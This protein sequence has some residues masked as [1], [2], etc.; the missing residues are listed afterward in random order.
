MHK[1]FKTAAFVLTLTAIGAIAATGPR[2]KLMSPVHATK[3]QTVQ[4]ATPIALGTGTYYHIPT[5]FASIVD[6][7]GDVASRPKYPFGLYELPSE[8]GQTL[9]AKSDNLLARYGGVAIDGYYYNI[10]QWGPIYNPTY[11]LRKFDMTTWELVEEKTLSD[12]SL[13]ADCMAYDP[14][15][16]KTYGCFRIENGNRISFKIGRT[17]LTS[18][19]PYRT[20]LLNCS[21]NS[22]RWNACACTPDGKLY[23][24]N[25]DGDLLRIDKST[26]KGSKIGS[27]GITPCNLAAATI[28]PET[29]IMYY[30]PS[31][32]DGSVSIY[33]VDLSSGKATEALRLPSHIVLTGLVPANRIPASGVPAIPSDARPEFKDGN[34]SGTINF[35]APSTTFDGKSASGQLRYEITD[36]DGGAVISSGT[37][38]Y[39]SNVS[40]PATLAASGYHNLVITTENSKGRSP[41]L[42]TRIYAGADKPRRTQTVTAVLNDATGEVSLS[43]DAVTE[44]VYGG[45]FNA[46]AVTYSVSDNTTGNVIA[47][48]LT[49][50]SYTARLNDSEELKCHR[51]DVRASFRDMVS[52]PRSSNAAVRGSVGLPYLNDFN[53]LASLPAGFDTINV[54]EDLNT[55]RPYLN[56]MQCYKNPDKVS[57]A[58]D[59]LMSPPVRLERGKTYQVS[60]DIANMFSSYYGL[61][62]RFEVKWGTNNTISAMTESGIQPTDVEGDPGDLIKYTN[63][64]FAITPEQSGIYYIGIHAISEANQGG[65]LLD[66]F[67]VSEPVD[68]GTPDAVTDLNIEPGAKGIHEATLTFKAPVKDL[69]GKSLSSLTKI[70]IIRDNNVVKTFDS[71][72]PGE[73]LTYTDKTETGGHKEYIVVGYNDKGRGATN[74]ASTWVGPYIPEACRDITL[75]ETSNPGE[76]NVGWT[77]PTRDTHAKLLTPEYLTYNLY[78]STPSGDELVREGMTGTSATYRAC[79]EDVQ[80]Y[81]IFGVTAVSAAGEG[82]GAW[83]DMIAVGKPYPLPYLFSFNDE[84]FKT[85]SIIR[86]NFGDYDWYVGDKESTGVAAADNDDSY[87][88]FSAGQP[89]GKAGMITGKIAVP[90]DGAPV[91]TFRTFPLKNDRLGTNANTIEVLIFDGNEWTTARTVAMS[92]LPNPEE[93]NKVSIALS[94]YRGK[95]IQVEFIGCCMSYP[96]VLLD[97]I[98]IL[99]DVASDIAITDLR[100]PELA[101]MN[102]Q[103]DI[104]VDILNAAGKPAKGYEIAV[105]INGVRRFTTP[106]PDIDGGKSST[107]KIPVTFAPDDPRDCRLQAVLVWD[108]D[109]DATNDRS[110]TVDVENNAPRFNR[111]LD[112]TAEEGSSTAR[113]TWTA[114]ESEGNVAEP[115]TD[116]FEEYAPWQS[117]KTGDWIMTDRDG[118]GIGGFTGFTFPGGIVKGSVQSWWIFDQTL[119]GLNSTFAAHSGNRYIGSMY[120]ADLSSSS[121][122]PVQCDDWAISPELCGADQ[123]ITLFARSYYPGK[124]ETAEFLYSTGSTDPDDFNYVELVDMIPGEWTRIDIELPEGARRFAVRSRSTDC[125]MLFVDDITYVAAGAEPFELL[126]YNVYR[127][128]QRLNSDLLKATEFTAPYDSQAANAYFVTAVY[129]HGES[130]ASNIV[131]LGLSGIG[132]IPGDSS[133][134]LTGIYT[135]TGVRLA[136]PAN[137][138]N[139]LTFSDGSAKKLIINN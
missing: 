14:T 8:E 50:T 56:R 57:A 15:E 43:W 91:L 25:M 94:E 82:E 45:Y 68:A 41:R 117:S 59:W 134:R 1:T 64:S 7:N 13:Y 5:L 4:K 83:S 42:Y 90:S 19:T 135:L 122:S 100:A 85:G 121:Y 12:N 103:F 108:E 123:R 110:A 77:P 74:R 67:A 46:D 10:T 126:G 92:S 88:V 133:V 81:V 105:E 61:I 52:D 17:D 65:L 28:D 98:E 55:W 129:N 27:T 128:G 40:A 58:D 84:D 21:G 106:G 9:E 24:I 51:F 109:E 60:M 97:R 26:G 2:M 16:E 54:R 35:K 75:S 114:P 22:D 18:D 139:I 104:D 116:S 118:G 136:R 96:A 62:E 86:H 137:G 66:N 73:S 76:V 132:G 11:Y 70:E 72:K 89:G 69:S 93:W 111:P 87:A 20:D 71:P 30:T 119:S 125:Y 36:G 39:G 127:N 130:A 23:A 32:A 38:S 112:L 31:L 3:D 49:S 102:R 138:V 34:L 101:R 47:D 95:S 113:L 6:D 124:L 37:T 99:A 79:S 33:I 120:S 63:Y 80:E 115:V 29:G 107:M 131:S 53:S 44:G 48:K 78:K